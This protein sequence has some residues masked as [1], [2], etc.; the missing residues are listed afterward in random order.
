[1]NHKLPFNAAW[2]RNDAKLTPVKDGAGGGAG[3]SGGAGPTGGRG[4]RKSG[5]GGGAGRGKRGQG[6]AR[7]AREGGRGGP[8]REAGAVELSQPQRTAIEMLT[9]GH[10]AIDSAMKAGVRRMTLYRWLKSDATFQAAYNAWRRDAL[11]TARGRM[12]ALTDVA[13]TAVGKAMA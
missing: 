7:G 6:R 2:A 3:A 1:M 11:A 5:G 13:V 10:T 9:S 8:A 4:D 12:L